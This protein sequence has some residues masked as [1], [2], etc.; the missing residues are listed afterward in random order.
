MVSGSTQIFPASTVHTLPRKPHRRSPRSGSESSPRHGRRLRE[1]FPAR[2]CTTYVGAGWCPGSTTPTSTPAD[3]EQLSTWNLSR[4]VGSR[5]GLLALLRE[6]AEAT[7]AGGWALG[8]RYDHTRH[9]GCAD[10]DGW[11]GGSRAPGVFV[12]QIGMHWA[13]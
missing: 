1:A 7:T 11:T 13:C 8:S 4:L 2:R 3:A 12:R 6:R 9:G 10:Q 5:S